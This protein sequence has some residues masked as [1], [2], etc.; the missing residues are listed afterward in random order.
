[1]FWRAVNITQHTQSEQS[2]KVGKEVLGQLKILVLG[3]LVFV[4]YLLNTI[5]ALFVKRELKNENFIFT[6]GLV[7]VRPKFSFLKIFLSVNT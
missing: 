4:E 1:M 6:R 7:G 3:G 5:Y 2:P